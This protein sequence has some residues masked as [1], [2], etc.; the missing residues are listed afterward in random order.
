M[1]HHHP[2]EEKNYVYVYYLAALLC[3]MFVGVILESSLVWIPVLG[4]FGLM[5]A[6]FF[7]NVFVR[8]RE[9]A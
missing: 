7:L 4:I 3:G 5:F 8:G 1:A 9:N 6:G 2:K